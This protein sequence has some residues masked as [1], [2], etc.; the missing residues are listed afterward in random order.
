MSGQSAGTERPNGR[1]LALVY[2]GPASSPGCPEAVAEVLAGSRWDLDVRFVGP[3][4]SLR[5]SAETLSHAL[6]YAQ[7]GGGSLGHAYRKL[8]KH[9]GAIREYV[10]AGGHYLGFCLGGYL[11]GASPGF[12]LLPGDADRFISSPG[13]YPRHPDQAVVT[14][15]WGGR[16]RP[17]YFQDGPW[18]DLD[19]ARGEADVLATYD[20]GL[21][22]AV[23]APFGRGGVGVVG[24]HPEAS[25]DWFLDEGL[26]V[27]RRLAYDLARD[28]L[29]RA[30]AL[31][32]TGSRAG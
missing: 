31:G 20:N 1:A 4:E 32:A 30:L 3:H 6:L 22:A 5:L 16:R 10:R 9:A 7:P 15:T 21:A 26:P 12:D 24:P 2:R 25:P 28:I 13:A 11:A 23:V 14:V 19:P 8:K 17:V 29:D 18:F 27:P